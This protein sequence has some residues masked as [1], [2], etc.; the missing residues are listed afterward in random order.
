M[1][2]S[3]PCPLSLAA[4]LALVAACGGGTGNPEFD[5]S[6]ETWDELRAEASGNYS[7]TRYLT[8]FQGPQYKT[9]FSVEDDVVVIRE[10]IPLPGS[11]HE[12]WYEYGN[13][14]GS[15]DDGHEVLTIDEIYDRCATDI[16][17]RDPTQYDIY[18]DY[19]TD[20]VL[21]TCH[22]SDPDFEDDN[23]EGVDIDSYDTSENDCLTG[24]ALLCKRRPGG[25]GYQSS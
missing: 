4:C 13:E 7:Y 21:H 12:A 10:L 23:N 5:Q 2:R 14:V 19:F 22:A 18:L 15:H 25:T 1:T 20:G 8:T 3:T 24:G 9:Y 11:D 6:R 17:Q 16:L